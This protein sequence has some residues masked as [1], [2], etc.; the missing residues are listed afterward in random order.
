ME[1]MAKTGFSLGRRVTGGIIRDQRY[2]PVPPQGV[3]Y[4]VEEDLSIVTAVADARLRRE[5]WE[6]AVQG[7]VQQQRGRQTVLNGD[8]PRHAANT[9]CH[10]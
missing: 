6:W 10:F 5:P 3:Y 4:H 2:W 1:W 8:T 7:F 9:N